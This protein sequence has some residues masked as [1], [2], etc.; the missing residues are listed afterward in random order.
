M[1]FSLLEILREYAELYVLGEL[2]RVVYTHSL[3]VRY[4]IIGSLLLQ[5]CMF[6]YSRGFSVGVYISG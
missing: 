5:V 4:E 6:G 1:L 3:G 2:V